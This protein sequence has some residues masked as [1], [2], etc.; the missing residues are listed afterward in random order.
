MKTIRRLFNRE[1]TA[2]IMF[3]LPFTLGFLFFMLVPMAIS[4]YYSS[5]EACICPAGSNAASK[6]YQNVRVLQSCILFAVNNWRICGSG[7]FVE[8]YVCY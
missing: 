4:L 5:F 7:N 2:G 1:D 3:T 6:E 8:T